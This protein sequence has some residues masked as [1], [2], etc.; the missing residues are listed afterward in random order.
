M[1]IVAAAGGC[2][3]KSICAGVGPVAAGS[4]EP[5]VIA[6]IVLGTGAGERT[7]GSLGLFAKSF[8]LSAARLRA[9]SSAARMLANLARLRA[10]ISPS[11]QRWQWAHSAPFAHPCGF[12]NQPHGLHSLV[13]CKAD[14]LEKDGVGKDRG[15]ARGEG[16]GEA[17]GDRSGEGSVDD[18]CE[19]ANGAG[20]GGVAGGS[21]R[22][23]GFSGVTNPVSLTSS[24][25]SCRISPGSV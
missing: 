11:G 3:K 21:G 10:F 1:A 23:S 20:G 5:I 6:G 2:D 19:T 9:R 22:R 4:I 18:V 15:E 24:S 14:P 13:L 25:S 16:S 12:Q 17:A 8:S 7:A